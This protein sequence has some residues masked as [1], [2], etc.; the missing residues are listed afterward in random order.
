MDTQ[1]Y[2]FAKPTVV[3]SKCLEFEACRYN[4]DR[5]PDQTVRNLKPYVRFIPVCPEV[6]IGLGTP[7]ETIRLVTG[8][9]DGIRLIQPSTGT[10]LTGKMD[11][12][13]VQFLD[14][15]EGEDV[16]GFIL[17]NRSPSCGIRDV[18]V[19][20]GA[21]RAPVVDRA[22]G[23]FAAHIL[24]RFPGQAI[25]EEGRLSNF[26]IR[27][28][29]LTKLFTMA[30]F[31]EQKQN[32]SMK[33][34][35]Q[36]HS[37][38]KYLF[39]AYNQTQLKEMGRVVANHEQRSIAQVWDKYGEHLGKLFAKAARYT[40]NINVCEHIMGYFK[41]ELSAKEKAYFKEL[42][43]KYQDRKIPL[44][45]LLTLLRSWVLRFDQIYLQ[46]QSFF[47]PYPEVLVELSDS[48]KGRNYS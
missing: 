1:P 24:E 32:P 16:D 11:T 9:G 3:V 28:H 5:V 43:V 42:L 46:Q 36:F 37:R 8:E 6:E 23:R 40:S 12:F 30:E 29:F 13:A 14:A 4:G 10:D 19:Y 38:H 18:K 7:R 22:S 31:R 35:V 47:E 27:E 21:E 44:G 20:A 39:M 45:N 15:L 34:L 48:G 26:T 25:E 2:Q 41:K 17:K 33:K